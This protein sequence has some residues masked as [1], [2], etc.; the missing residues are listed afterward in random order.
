MVI[1]LA[2]L[3]IRDVNDHSYH[4]QPFRMPQDFVSE[5]YDG[6]T[7]AYV[8]LDKVNEIIQEGNHTRSIIEI[9]KYNQ[10]FEQNEVKLEVSGIGISPEAISSYFKRFF[11]I[12]TNTIS[13]EFVKEDSK[14]KLF[15][16]ITGEPTQT[17]AESTDSLGK[18][19]AFKKLIQRGAESILKMNNPTLLALYYGSNE[20]Y[21]QAFATFR[22]AIQKNPQMTANIYAWWAEALYFR[23]N[24]T[25]YAM[26]KIRQALSVDPTNAAA[27]NI[28]GNMYK[29]FGK[30]YEEQIRVLRK[31]TE[32]DPNCVACWNDLGATLA[33][34][35]RQGDKKNEAEA[36]TCFEKCYSLDSTYTTS[37]RHWADLLFLQ[38]K[39]DEASEKIE[40]VGYHRFDF[41]SILYLALCIARNDKPQISIT[42]KNILK[43]VPVKTV[44]ARLNSGAFRHEQR[45]NY[46]IAFKLVRFALEKDST[47]SAAALPLSTLAEL[48][49]LTGN[50]E[51]F[52]RHIDKALKLGLLNDIDKNDL[53]EDEPYKSLSNEKR[54]QELLKKNN[55]LFN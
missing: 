48:E 18:Y 33:F 29:Y 43:N 6:T 44:I 4:I 25:T 13:G 1:I 21:D 34:E 54:F 47:T 12:Q 40:K 11:G 10:N 35:S 9:E 23:D 49:V 15:L 22:F 53:K 30:N 55:I 20:D 46:D 28:W 31:A 16:R 2:K 26:P 7:T 36:I 14:L 24:D 19:G 3:I 39:I 52:Y 27:Y 42:Y 5:G 51:G 38:G 32:L 45:G 50:K 8:I 37:F 41:N 17:I